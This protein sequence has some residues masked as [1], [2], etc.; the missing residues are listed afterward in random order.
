[1]PISINKP[2]AIH[3][4]NNYDP[5]TPYSTSEFM[6]SANIKT[7]VTTVP[8]T[9]SGQSSRHS[10][11]SYTPR[12]RITAIGLR[13]ALKL[14]ETKIHFKIPIMYYEKLKEGGFYEAKSTVMTNTSNRNI[15][16]CLDMRNSNKITEQG[17]FKICNG[18]KVPFVNPS[19]ISF[20]PE[21]EIK[22]NESFEFQILFCPGLLFIQKKHL[23]LLAILNFEIEKKDQPGIYNCKIPIV[24]NDNFEQ[25][26]YFIEIIGELLAPELIFD[27]EVLILKP[28]PLGIETVEKFLIKHSGYET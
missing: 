20:G 12:R 23:F 22:P 28:V 27:P 2:A 24:V 3:L 6:A 25:P 7:P 17:I 19:G 18:S 9:R 21:G 10:S 26:Y 15:K 1:L 4:Y 14:T 11:N 16:W 5:M 8:G 13:S